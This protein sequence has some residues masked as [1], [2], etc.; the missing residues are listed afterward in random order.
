MACVGRAA[1]GTAG[2]VCDKLARGAGRHQQSA[3]WDLLG[4]HRCAAPSGAAGHQEVPLRAMARGLVA[5]GL[6]P[7]AQA[8]RPGHTGKLSEGH[9]LSVRHGLVVQVCPL[10][11]LPFL[12]SRGMGPGRAGVS[13]DKCND[14]NSST[15]RQHD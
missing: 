8:V 14:S 3:G 1:G 11:V 13:S 7:Q 10:E 12:N 4:G 9:T 6:A 15:H 2:G 5:P